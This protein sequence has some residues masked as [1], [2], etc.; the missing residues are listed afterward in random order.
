MKKISI[1]LFFI[2]AAIAANAQVF[3]AR[4][5]NDSII[6]GEQTKISI[7]ATL[8]QN[9]QVISQQ[10]EDTICDK[11]FLINDS[12][13][14][15]NNTFS[16]EYTITAFDTGINIINPLPFIVISGSDTNVFFTDTLALKVNPYVLIDTIPRDT[17]FAQKPGIVLF[18]KDGFRN[19][20]D[21]YIPDSIKN[22]LPA[23]SLNMLK[24]EIKRQFIQQ[25]ASMVMQ[26]GFT[27]QEHIDSVAN[28]DSHRIFIVD[29]EILETHY[30]Y[31]SVDSVFV[32]ENQQVQKDDILF[33]TFQIKDID[34]ELYNTPFT[35][36]EFWYYVK[37][38]FSEFWWIL[39]ILIIAGLAIYYYIYKK[40]HGKSPLEM[41]SVKPKRPAHEIALEELERIRKEKIW[42]RG[43][44]KE[45]HVQ[46]SDVV[47][48]YISNRYGIEAEQMTTNQILSLMN[49]G[50]EIGSE[51]IQRV[52]QILELADAV[53]FAKFQPM[54]GDNDLSLR[55]A[56]EFV[57]DSKEIVANT[58]EKDVLAEIE[59]NKAS[60]TE[61]NAKEQ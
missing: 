20:I 37:K 35:L 7:N 39:V 11:I 51:N 36:A 3:S 15:E 9:A 1:I 18:G 8:P 58:N 40:R 21:K 59:V 14:N 56:F 53:K 34:D 45:Y 43:Q 6:V 23:D 17:V 24:E 13:T 28:A 33:T 31:G 54:Q 2:V 25:Y 30:I 52:R 50:I 26:S 41:I 29:K 42:N 27:N 32:Q 12:T 4:L 47:R 57:E 22:S 49:H 10:Y 19:E 48:A 61:T 38:Y 44:V 60:E 16:K 55:N 46:I 5:Q